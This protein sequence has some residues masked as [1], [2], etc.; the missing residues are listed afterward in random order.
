[1]TTFNEREKS[2]EKKFAMDEELSFKADARRNRLLAHWVGGQARAHGDGGR[3]LRQG[4][5]QGGSGL[6]GAT[7]TCSVKIKKDLEDKGVA[8]ADKEL[9]KAMDDFLAQACGTSRPRAR[10]RAEIRELGEGGRPSDA[11][12]HRG[13][14]AQPP[15]AAD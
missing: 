4:R 8:V 7:R 5:A 10:P 12:V 13:R 14:S 15:E 3:R 2:F 11:D 9:R 6:Q 1:M